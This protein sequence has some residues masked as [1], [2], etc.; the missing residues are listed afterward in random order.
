MIANISQRLVQLHSNLVEGIA[1]VKMQAKSIALVFSQGVEKSLDG[2]ISDQFTKR[3]VRFPAI[4]A[5][6][7]YFRRSIEIYMCVEVTRLQVTAPVDGPMVGHL[8]NPGAR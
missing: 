5:W 3:I 7:K 4:R 1:L 8:D 6:I 2:R